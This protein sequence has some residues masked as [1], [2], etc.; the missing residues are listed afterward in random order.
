MPFACSWFSCQVGLRASIRDRD[1]LMAQHYD[2]AA[3]KSFETRAFRGDE[4][5]DVDIVCKALDMEI[6]KQAEDQYD[7]LAAKRT[8]KRAA[9]SLV[10]APRTPPASEWKPEKA[11]SFCGKTNH[12]VKDCW[13]KHGKPSNSNNHARPNKRQYQHSQQDSHWAKKKKYS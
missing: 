12:S 4:D 10:A 8:T 1:I 7:L 5:F 2:V 9:S 11:C 13:A 6:L 3:R